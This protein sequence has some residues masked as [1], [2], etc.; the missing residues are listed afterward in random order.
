VEALHRIREELGGAPG[1]GERYV[2]F[3]EEFT[4]TPI[5]I[6]SVGYERSATIIRRKPWTRY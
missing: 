1:R 5:G 6:I 2:S 4:G 3:I